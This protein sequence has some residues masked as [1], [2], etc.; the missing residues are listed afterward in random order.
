VKDD[1]RLLIEQLSDYRM[2]N[3]LS[4]EELAKELAVSFVTVNRWLNHRFLPDTE[5]ELKIRKLLKTDQ[6]K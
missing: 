4:Q 3:K 1:K 6:K 5:Q 2:R